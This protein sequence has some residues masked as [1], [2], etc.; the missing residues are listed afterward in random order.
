M[1]IMRSYVIGDIHGCPDE[2]VYLVQALPL[3][4]G[5]RLVF[6]GDYIDRGPDSSGVISFLL[7]LQ[8]DRG[9]YEFVFLKGYHEDMRLYYLGSAGQ[10]GQMELFSEVQAT[11][12]ST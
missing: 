10:H 9:A 8:K 3:E 11:Q 4:S 2:L 1:T 12:A 7:E 5:D 6:L